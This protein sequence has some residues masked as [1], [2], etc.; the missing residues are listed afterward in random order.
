M[1]K[2]RDAVKDYVMKIADKEEYRLCEY[3]RERVFTIYNYIDIPDDLFPQVAK[4]AIVLG[5]N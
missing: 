5:F 4:W 2:T 3:C 1:C